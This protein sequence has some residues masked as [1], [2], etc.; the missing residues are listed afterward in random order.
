MKLN[1]NAYKVKTPLAET[2][3]FSSLRLKHDQT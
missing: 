3:Q 2:M 1:L